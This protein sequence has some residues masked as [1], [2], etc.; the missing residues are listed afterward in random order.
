LKRYNCFEKETEIYICSVYS[1][2]DLLN[3][4][5]FLK[6]KGIEIFTR[7][8]KMSKHTMKHVWNENKTKDATITIASSETQPSLEGE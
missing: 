5:Q 3:L 4:E 1:Y 8:I 2:T 6:E 7:D